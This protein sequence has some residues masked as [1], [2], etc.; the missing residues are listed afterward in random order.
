MADIAVGGANIGT[1]TAV[2]RFC[3]GYGA[4]HCMTQVLQRRKENY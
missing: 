1:P 4:A 2:D 3:G